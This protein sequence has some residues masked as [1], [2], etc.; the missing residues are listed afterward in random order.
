MF[1]PRENMKSAKHFAPNYKK[2][3]CIFRFTFYQCKYHLYIF[4]LYIFCEMFLKFH[5]N[6]KKKKSNHDLEF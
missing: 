6:K 5:F 3:C 4:F 2:C 1:Y